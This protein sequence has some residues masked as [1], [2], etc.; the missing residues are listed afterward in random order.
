M[1]AL[2]AGGLAVFDTRGGKVRIL[3]RRGDAPTWSPDSRWLAYVVSEGDEQH[4]IYRVSW[5]GGKRQRL[6]GGAEPAWSPDGS[7]IAF[8]RGS[9]K[10]IDVMDVDGDNVRRLVDAPGN[11]SV[12]AP[13]WS[14]DGRE[15]AFAVARYNVPVGKPSLEAIHADG[16]DRRT[17]ATTGRLSG[18]EPAFAWAPTGR[19]L[20]FDGGIYT[21][22]I[23]NAEGTG[24][25]AILGGLGGEAETPSWSPDGSRVAYGPSDGLWV[26]P[27]TGGKAVHVTRGAVALGDSDPQWD[28]LGRHASQLGGTRGTVPPIP[29]GKL[30]AAGVQAPSPVTLLVA[31]GDRGAY[32]SPVEGC[33][34]PEVWEPLTRGL[35]AVANDSCTGLDDETSEVAIA[36][37]RV[38]WLHT[39][40]EGS[41]TYLDLMTASLARPWQSVDVLGANEDA[42]N[43]YGEGALLVFNTGADPPRLWRLATTTKVRR[44]LVKK[45][46]DAFA[47]SVGA[48]LI[49]ARRLDGSVAVLRADGTLLRRFKFSPSE[50]HD[51]RLAKRKLI[52]VLTH[53]ITIY[54]ADS[55]R[56]M[57]NLPLTTAGFEDADERNAAFVRGSEVFIVDLASG[58]R[59]TIARGAARPVHAALGDHGIFYSFGRTVSFKRLKQ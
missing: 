15:L 30:V 49:A 50:L 13:A 21:L 4:A 37:R 39:G 31:D 26:I 56:L 52:I 3:D 48:G 38:L 23:V 44:S 45:G 59:Q 2:P 27:T 51:T 11:G 36:G 32:V 7:A 14:P 42:Y 28:R 22:S 33:G 10:E 46:P 25:R 8:V 57:K 55:G 6:T 12:S 40:T 18:F 1:F 54:D 29:K 16:S 34:G 47:S 24:R 58:R 20:A 5:D 43:L 41:N 53:A 19:A 35:H 9:G 17:I